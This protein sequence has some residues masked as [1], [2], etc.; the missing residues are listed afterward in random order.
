MGITDVFIYGASGHGKVVYDIALRNNYTVSGFIDDNENINEFIG[1]KV[2]RLDELDD[3]INCIL[4]IGD[5]Y[6][7]QKVYNKVKNKKIKILNVYDPSSI[8]NSYV[9]IGEGTVIMP[10]VVVNNSAKIGRG[11]I[12]NTGAVVEH[13]CKINDFVHISPNAS[14]AGGVSVGEFS[15]IG[16][17]ACV[18]QNV[19]IGKNVIV[20]A[21]SVVVKNIPDNVIVAGNP[22]KILRKNE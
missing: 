12:L 6:S 1:L 9:E 3:S 22:A 8:L 5:N 20:G 16:I 11:C 15:Q 21:G 10:M 19:K 13:D 17:G 18:R 14:L 2:Y 4:G 7:R